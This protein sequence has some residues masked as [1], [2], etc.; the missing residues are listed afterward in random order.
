MINNSKIDWAEKDSA[1][2]RFQRGVCGA[3]FSD[4]STTDYREVFKARLADMTIEEYLAMH[5]LCEEVCGVY[6]SDFRE[7]WE[8]VGFTTQE[9]LE[10]LVRMYNMNKAKDYLW[11]KYPDVCE[12]TEDIIDF[13][14][15]CRYSDYVQELSIMWESDT[16][17]GKKNLHD[18]IREIN[19]ERAIN[20]Y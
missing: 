8:R 16:S 6:P 5:G 18:T 20:Q 1:K 7:S 3:D 19:I 15:A 14:I 9:Q 2:F 17:I 13:H 4:V 12:I 10:D 11:S